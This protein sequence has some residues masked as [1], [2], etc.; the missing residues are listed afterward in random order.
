MQE[1]HLHQQLLPE[2]HTK[3][4]C[5]F[6]VFMRAACT[7]EIAR[8]CHHPALSR[9]CI[10]VY[11]SVTGTLSVKR[12]VV[13]AAYCVPPNRYLLPILYGMGCSMLSRS[14]AGPCCAVS[15]LS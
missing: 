7:A 12:F 11:Y 4:S 13:T 2:H 3:V 5:S 6:S 15:S 8:T 10:M 9:T 14:T 1:K